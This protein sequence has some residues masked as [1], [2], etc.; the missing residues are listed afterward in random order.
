MSDVTV[1]L[2]KEKHRHRRQYS[3]IKDLAVVKM[4][5]NLLQKQIKDDILRVEIKHSLDEKNS[6]TLLA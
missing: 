4:H 6:A 2:I 3:Q 1:A 5:I